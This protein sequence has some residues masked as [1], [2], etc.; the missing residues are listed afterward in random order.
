MTGQLPRPP[1]LAG[2]E[3]IPAQGMQ[4]ELSMDMGAAGQVVTYAVAVTTLESQAWT[5]VTVTW[6]HVS[7]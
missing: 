3:T 2:T 5:A 6:V 4:L 7:K 1:A